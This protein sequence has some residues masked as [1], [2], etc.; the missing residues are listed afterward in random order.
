[1]GR[2]PGRSLPDRTQPSQRRLTSSARTLPRRPRTQS[3]AASG[4]GKS[5]AAEQGRADAA[6]ASREAHA[7]D[8]PPRRRRSEPGEPGATRPQSASARERQRLARCAARCRRRVHGGRGLRGRGLRRRGRGRPER[9]RRRA[10]GEVGG[11]A[12][13][14]GGRARGRERRRHA[15][16]GSDLRDP[17]GARPRT[18][19]ASTPRACSR[20]CP[21]ASASCARRT[22]TT[23]R[24]P[25]TSTCRPRRSAASASAPATPCSGRCVRPRK[26]SATS[27]C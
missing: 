16:A 9:Q 7:H 15:Q 13:R 6:P 21:T 17:E 14:D 18:R 23:W 19:A 27:R 2:F 24:V 11:R 3:H 5:A 8:E 1:M 12:R 25:T 10:E 22:R 4:C 20:R 26:A